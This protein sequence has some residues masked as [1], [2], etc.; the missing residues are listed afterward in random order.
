MVSQLVSHSVIHSSFIQSFILSNYSFHSV[1]PLFLSFVCIDCLD[2]DLTQTEGK[3]I[4]FIVAE[5][6]NNNNDNNNNNFI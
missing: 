1:V 2:L 3:H 6:K 4:Q 5:V